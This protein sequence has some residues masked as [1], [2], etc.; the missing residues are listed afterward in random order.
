MKIDKNI[1]NI[2]PT[3]LSQE[4]KRYQAFYHW[5]H[6]GKN[7]SHDRCNCYLSTFRIAEQF[8]IAN[9]II[10]EPLI[11]T[12]ESA[13]LTQKIEGIFQH[14][15]FVAYNDKKIMNCT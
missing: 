13:L 3:D 1:E 7:E 6:V 2:T 9:H 14:P 5:L 15:L 8:C 11:K 12:E 4:D 10:T